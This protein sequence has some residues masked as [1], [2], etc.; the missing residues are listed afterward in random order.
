MIKRRNE[1]RPPTVLS[2][3]MFSDLDQT[4]RFELLNTL[5]IK[6]THHV[7]WLTTPTLSLPF[8]WSFQ[9]MTEEDSSHGDIAI[10]NLEKKNVQ[11]M[12]SSA[13]M[14]RFL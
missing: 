10:Y 11:K 12:T 3:S 7:F 6:H 8:A 13:C 2:A 5:N 14:T 9:M 4:G 1:K